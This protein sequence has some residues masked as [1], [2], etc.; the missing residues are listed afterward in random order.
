VGIL[1]GRPAPRDAIPSGGPQ[2][3]PG[4]LARTADRIAGSDVSSSWC[5]LHRPD[6]VCLTAAR[7]VPAGPA[8]DRAATGLTLSRRERPGQR[9][10]AAH[11]RRPQRS[12]SPS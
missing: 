7:A 12:A 2:P 9:A 10:Q 3:V 5:A 11:R 8:P 6:P 4:G 1:Y